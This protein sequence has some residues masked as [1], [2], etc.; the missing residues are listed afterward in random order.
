M[1]VDRHAN[2]EL[3]IFLEFAAVCPL[4]ITRDSIEKRDP[5]EPDILCRIRDGSAL[6]FELVELVDRA[7]IAKPMAD[8]E[9]LMDSLR[10][11]SRA[12]PEET[13]KQLKDAWVG[14]EFRPD[15][16]LRKRKEY[17]RQ[18]VE[19]V[20]ADP[21][22]EGKVAVRERDAEVA[23]ANVKRR[24]GLDGPH[25]RV[26]VAGH[27]EPVPLGAIEEKFDKAY[28]GGNPVDLLA[29]FDRQHAPLEAQIGKLVAFVEANIARSPYGRV[30]IFDRHNHR[31][32]YPNAELR[33]VR[34]E[35]PGKLLI[36]TP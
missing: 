36:E 16:T 32:W 25:F 8:Q 9:Q 20:A 24:E 28:Q 17:A 29:H 12:L 19:Q 4:G 11:A 5:P 10:E 27:Y 3:T 34:K 23:R 7:R 14:V 35:S 31:I 22:V 33:N 15:R 6:A 26:I 2:Q 13:R 21:T 18:L 30:W 1:I